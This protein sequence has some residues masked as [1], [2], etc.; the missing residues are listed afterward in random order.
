M[1]T[2]ILENLPS[3]RQVS[4]VDGTVENNKIIRAD[5]VQDFSAHQGL[6]GRAVFWRFSKWGPWTGGIGIS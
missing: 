3:A 4:M 2:E 5:I 1:F 6:H